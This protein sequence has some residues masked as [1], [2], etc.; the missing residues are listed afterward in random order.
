M[1]LLSYAIGSLLTPCTV[2]LPGVLA[3]IEVPHVVLDGQVPEAAPVLSAE[4]ADAGYVVTSSRC[5]GEGWEGL[6][7]CAE[8]QG[9]RA[10]LRIRVAPGPSAVITVYDARTSKASA[11]ETDDVRPRILALMAVELLR[12]SLRQ[13]EDRG[14][15]LPRPDAHEHAL[16]RHRRPRFALGVGAAAAW[17]LGGGRLWGHP[18]LRARWTPWSGVG[19]EAFTWLPGHEHTFTDV[20]GRARVRY[21]LAAAGARVPL[22]REDRALQVDLGGGGGALGLWTRGDAEAPF[23]SRT[24]R[25]WTGLLY[26][27]AGLALALGVRARWRLDLWTALA[28]PRL[29]VR[30][31]ETRVA[32]IAAPT[33]SASSGI[34]VVLP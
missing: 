27:R 7:T 26:A 16:L 20:Q 34:E 31:D 10:A 25:V 19:F 13:L 12:A 30:F 8:T 23:V 9:A 28:V 2:A 15:A 14:E 6:R 22:R 24:D 29:S 33:L 3:T 32:A 5:P 4:L 21:G 1:S 17:G 18:E 11:R